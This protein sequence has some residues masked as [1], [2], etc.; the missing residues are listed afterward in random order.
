M[1]PDFA[2]APLGA[3][4]LLFLAPAAR[5]VDVTFDGFADFRLVAPADERSWIDG[6]L[7]KSR[8]GEG[9]SNFQFRRLW[10][11]NGPAHAGAGAGN[12]V[13]ARP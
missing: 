5:A 13:E 1:R 4:T 7:G 12:F 8:Y 2:L 9:N 10:A 11:G 3:A 6:G